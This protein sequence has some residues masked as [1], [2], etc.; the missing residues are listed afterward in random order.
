VFH[1]DIE[2]AVW[3]VT[4]LRQFSCMC[5]R[6][7]S[8][9]GRK[10]KQVTKVCPGQLFVNLETRTRSQVLNFNT[11]SGAKFQLAAVEPD[12]AITSPTPDLPEGR[13]SNIVTLIRSN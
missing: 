12:V 3:Y 11:Q 4:R 8:Y 1:S 13:H 10:N 7:I 5:I 2:C 9:G 6:A